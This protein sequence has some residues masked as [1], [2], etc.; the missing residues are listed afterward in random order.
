MNEESKIDMKELEQHLLEL[1]R[2][3]YKSVDYI[4]SVA[5]EA[6][7]SAV[8]RASYWALKDAIR[9]VLREEGLHSVLV[10]K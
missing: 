10:K 1:S 3:A 8:Y 2:K 7:W 5:S 9:E 4:E 6:V